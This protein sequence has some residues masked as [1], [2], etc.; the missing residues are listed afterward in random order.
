LALT[1][2]VRLGP[3]EVTAKLGEGGMGEVYRATDTTLKREVA[4]KV[5]PEALA[6][7]AERLARFQREAESLAALNHPNIAQIYGIEESGARALSS[8]SHPS[9]P[10]SARGVTRALVMELVEGED[11][12]ARIRRGAMPLED[13]LPIA[14]QIADALTAAHA[15]GIIHR[16]LKP[17]NIK[18]RDDGTVKVLDFGLAKALAP[19]DPADPRAQGLADLTVTSPAMTQL[20]LILGT[21]A[22]MSPEQAKGKPVDA[23]ADVWAFGCVLYE[24][25][26]GRQ[27]WSGETVTDVIAALVAREPDW[28]RLPPTVSPRLRYLLER[29][30]E[31]DPARRTQ[32]IAEVRA[33]L[34]RAAADPAGATLALTA[35]SPAGWRSR[36]AWPLTTLVVALA[37]AAAVWAAMRPEPASP[38]WLAVV[39]PGPESFGGNDFNANLAVSP[40]GTR[41]AYTATTIRENA[42]AMPLYG[43]ALHA[44]GP[45]LL[46]NDARAPFFSPDG[47]WVGF[48]SNNGPLMKVAFAGGPAVTIGGNA[49]ANRG[50]TWGPG[51]TIVFAASDRVR[52]LSRISDTGGGTEEALTTPDQRQG[53]VDHLFPAFLPDGH[54]LLFTIEYAA[55]ARSIAVL[56]LDTGTYRTLI[57]S[58]SNPQYA[59]SGHIVYCVD[60]TLRAV[61]FDADR[62]EI[63]GEPVPVLDGVVTWVSGAGS[64]GVA[65]SGTLVYFSGPAETNRSLGLKEL[66]AIGR[67]GTPGRRLTPEARRYEAF[68]VSPDGRRI[69]VEVQGQGADSAATQ[70]WI[71]DAGSGLAT[72]LTFEGTQN[73]APVW[74]RDGR[75]LFFTSNRDAN[76]PSAIYRQAAD[77]SGEAEFVYRSDAEIYT[78]DMLSARVLLIEVGRP[79]S[80]QSL[81]LDTGAVATVVP[82]GSAGVLDARVSPDGRW[83]AYVSRD[84]RS[85]NDLF[86]RPAPPAS[87]AQ[88]RVSEG[89]GARPAW[90]PTG[91]ELIFQSAS[92]L[93]AMPVQLETGFTPGRA[94]S[95]F[96]ARRFTDIDYLAGG[97]FVGIRSTETEL[98][99]RPEEHLI[100]VQHWFEELKRLAP[101]SK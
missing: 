49:N 62:R 37:A 61:A 97:D 85:P 84:A 8:E 2:G 100:V 73:Y 80:I 16:D 88:R 56:D 93:M 74:S 67:D 52:G 99:T 35:A 72:Q 32:N 53:E 90:A 26:S 79:R 86:V 1:P 33:E 27:I 7:D 22:Y 75:T 55:S 45:V 70:V 59:A 101:A 47:T 13:A 94:V 91:R 34:D 4:I 96:S 57:P 12:S 6:G 43:R 25:L 29:C 77:F 76:A 17:A 81:D 63:R 83:I 42:N 39:H 66:V 48:V 10:E 31:K 5:L 87:G 30:L 44:R 14:R 92:G 89:D 18:V 38:T 24:M 58:G 50:I 9:S 23:R 28:H 15:R 95:L 69:A 36:L 11:L 51:G 40:D 71:V 41:I 65:A 20:G 78:D 3:Y 60:G 21:A 54:A 68:R 46:A 64:F 19:G 98:P 82:A